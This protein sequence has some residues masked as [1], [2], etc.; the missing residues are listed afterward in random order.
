MKGAP[1]MDKTFSVNHPLLFILA[2]LT[3]LFVALQSVVFL[4][5]AWKRALEKGYSKEQLKKTAV[6][7]AIFSIAPAVAIGI[8]II[9]LA[10]SLGT[11]LP[12]S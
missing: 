1:F 11:P 7:A 2:G 3:V 8:G 12:M 4:R 9:T 10:G 5:K 6:S